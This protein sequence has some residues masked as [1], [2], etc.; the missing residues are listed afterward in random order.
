M[1]T[2]MHQRRKPGDGGRHEVSATAIGFGTSRK[3]L[4]LLLIPTRR[5]QSPEDFADDGARQRWKSS[6]AMES[7]DGDM[8]RRHAER[9]EVAIAGLKARCGE[10][11][12]GRNP[13]ITLP[14]VGRRDAR[15]R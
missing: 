7:L 2:K 11:R 4:R 1:A 5:C 10:L 9:I 8:F 14:K 6:D 15:R 13:E 12:H 3:L